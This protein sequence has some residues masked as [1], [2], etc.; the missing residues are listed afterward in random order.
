MWRKL[1]I[2]AASLLFLFLLFLCVPVP[3][4]DSPLSTVLLADDGELL[5]AR[6]AEDGQWRFPASDDISEKYLRC[7]VEYEDKYFFR[8]PGINPVSMFN[9]AITNHKVKRVV[10][11][12]STITMQVVRL[13]R[14][15]R[16][17]TYAEK[18]VEVFLALRLELRYSKRE[19]L[20][21]YA[22]NAPFGGNIV[23]IDAASWRFFNSSPQNLTWAEAA[24]LA[25]L[26]NAPSVIHVS[27]N[28]DALEK[29]RNTL[30]ANMVDARSYIPRRFGGKEI[31]SQEDYE[32][33]VMENIPSEP[34]KMPQAAFHYLCDI[35][36]THKGEIYH[37]DIDYRLQNDILT[38][39]DAHYKEN[40]QNSIENSAVYVVDY[41]NGE[42]VAYVGNCLLAK[43]AAMVDMVRAN[44]ST[45]SILKPFLYAAML[46]AGE[47]LPE[48]VLPD[49][50]VNISGYT[51]KNY[52]GDYWGAVKADEALANSLNTPFVYLLRRFSV[53]KFYNIL[54]RCGL[55]GL[56]YP[57]DHYGLSLILGG[58]EA[59]LF[60]ITNTYAKMARVL[61][62]DGFYPE[63]QRAKVPPSEC[64]K[65]PSP[66]CANVPLDGA[67]FS[68]A[69][70]AATFKAMLNVNR[71]LEQVGWR[72][73]NSTKNVAWK[74]GTSFG[75]RDAW[76]VGVI[77]RY[78]VGVWVG[79]SDGEGRASLT[80]VGAAAPILF[81]VVSKVREAY[82]M[83]NI[84]SDAVEIEVCAIS[85]YPKSQYCPVTKQV[86]A[87]DCELLTG[88]C[89][90]HKKE[91]LDKTGQ[92]RVSPGC[93]D[94]DKDNYKIYYVLPPTME[95][96]Y[97]RH[98]ASY[99]SLPP[100]YP[101]CVAS[102]DEEVMSFIYP[103]ASAS[104]IIPVGIKGD[105]QAIVF[106]VAHRN[107]EK[108]VFWNLND[109][110]LGSTK[111]THQMLIDAPPGKYVLRCVD[112]DGNEVVRQL[113]INN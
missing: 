33:A 3:R 93:Y 21:L 63:K 8:H 32:L 9:A 113:T 72:N 111:K 40:S 18:I 65:V 77:D 100:L 89:P 112:D 80:G 46:D 70:I 49:I 94:F 13:A 76:S 36:K 83:S 69:A 108:T 41:I 38:I 91:F 22:A 14:E 92:Y 56:T 2:V 4:F 66:E 99:V 101:G 44:R 51:P 107:P 27:K 86:L 109:K 74:T 19:I 37:S 42:I 23:G 34:Y 82:T 88:V 54:K 29:K 96:F 12:G 95:W 60:D 35:E 110:Y 64:A 90:Y 1:I 104:I 48:M 73:F 17:R 97:K 103:D 68:P 78:V 53:P 5:G 45:G 10:R 61:Y 52:S 50:P 98:S 24:A 62:L 67:P 105:R 7:L 31:F 11:G 84:T 39:V 75:H 106:E 20:G 47:L 71:P 85:G 16:P 15:G 58:A 55:S 59:S 26:P 81:D 79:N 25:V 28:R 6:I 30:L 102:K 87:P 57:Y 43:D